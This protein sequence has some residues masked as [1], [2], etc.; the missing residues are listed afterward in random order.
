MSRF[1][2]SSFN[3][4]KEDIEESTPKNTKASNKYVWRQFMSFCND[5]NYSLNEHTTISCLAEILTDWAFNMRKLNGEEYKEFTVKTIW[6]VTAKLLMQ[7]FFN[8]YNIIF[9]PF[10]DIEFKKARDAKNAKRKQLQKVPE[11]RKESAVFLTNQEYQKLVAGCDEETPDGLQ[12]KYSLCLL[13][14]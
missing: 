12:K 9:N 14:S 2:T 6:N 3:S 10:S 11:K 8:D 5:K 7:K 13:L 1:G 4:I